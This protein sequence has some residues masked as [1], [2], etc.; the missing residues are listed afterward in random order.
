M[1]Y[2]VG[3]LW[4]ILLNINMLI[5]NEFR[6]EIHRRLLHWTAMFHDDALRYS[7]KYPLGKQTYWEQWENNV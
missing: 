4:H 3:I 1:K 2:A 7:L 5:V 6:Q